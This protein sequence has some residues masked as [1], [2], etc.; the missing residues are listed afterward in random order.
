MVNLFKNEIRAVIKAAN[1]NNVANIFK[2]IRIK[3]PLL[4]FNDFKRTFKITEHLILNAVKKPVMQILK[5]P[6]K[7]VVRVSFYQFTM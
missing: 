5:G 2:C 4:Y 3:T 6:G 1:V 7:Y